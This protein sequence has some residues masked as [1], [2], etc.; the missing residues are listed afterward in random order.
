MAGENEEGHGGVHLWNVPLI[1]M[2]ELA[3]VLRLFRTLQHA[4][5]LAVTGEC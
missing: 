1:N 4:A 3:L 2:S 5:A